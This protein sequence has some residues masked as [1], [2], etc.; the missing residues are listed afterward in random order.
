MTAIMDPEVLGTLLREYTGERLI[1]TRRVVILL[2]WWDD[3]SPYELVRR[4]ERLGLARRGT[5]R[6]FR[7]NGGIT[8]DHIRQV[9]ADLSG[10]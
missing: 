1:L 2:A 6:W 9:F 5:W 3:S 4:L 7:R 10:A 8:E